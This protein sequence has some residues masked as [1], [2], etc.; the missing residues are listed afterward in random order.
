MISK[1]ENIEKVEKEMLNFAVG[2]VMAAAEVRS[3]GALNVPYFRTEEFSALMLE[4]ERLMLEFS[5][6]PRGS[7][8][9]FLTTSG[10]GGMEAAVINT[11]S[12]KDKVLLINGGGFGH[13]FA[14]LL[15]IHKIPFAEVNPLPGHSVKEDDLKPF[16]NGG[17][18]AFVVN[19]DETSTGV[20]YDLDVISSFCKRNGLFLIVDAISSFLADK[21]DMSAKGIDVLIT[22]SQKALA[23]PPGVALLVLSPKALERVER[24]ETVCM[25][26]DLKIALKNGERGQTP[27]TPA[28]SVLIQMNAR[29]NQIKE[30]GGADYEIARTAERA[31]FFREN[32]QD[33]PFEFFSE[34]MSNAVTPLHPLTCDAFKIFEIIKNEYGMYICP[35]GGD[36]RNTVFRVGHIGE[37]SLDDYR[38]LIE[39]F[40]DLRR[41]GVI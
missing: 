14:E 27:F 3:L 16:D 4:N 19:I 39:A 1:Y 10:T 5:Y 24:S 34:R 26:L 8:A 41:R 13:R 28:V 7:R 37:L 18:T 15:T 11:L 2:P 40:R 21:I 6:A 35:N 29:L 12:G 25:Y 17:F 31:R 20:L 9:V 33:L 32:I 22:G 36:L 23:L 30:N 38:T